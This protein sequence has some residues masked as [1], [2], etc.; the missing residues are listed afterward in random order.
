VGT[1]VPGG[2]YRYFSE[3]IQTVGTTH[4]A[5]AHLTDGTTTVYAVLKSNDLITWSVAHN[6]GAN[7]PIPSGA[8]VPPVSFLL[9]GKWY[10][11]AQVGANNSWLVTPDGTTFTTVNIQAA[12]TAFNAVLGGQFIPVSAA[13]DGATIRV[14]SPTPT[15]SGQQGFLKSTDNGVTWAYE[16]TGFSGIDVNSIAYGNG[17]WVCGPGAVGQ[18]FIWTS[19]TGNN[20]TW[21]QQLF[22]IVTSGGTVHYVTDV[23]FLAGLFLIPNPGTN[24]GRVSVFTSSDGLNYTFRNSSNYLTMT[25]PQNGF[26]SPRSRMCAYGNNTLVLAGCYDSGVTNYPMIS[27]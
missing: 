8:T 21:T 11:L 3:T 19:T 4:L 24:P 22:P 9:N 10:T 5:V 14:A 6:Y 25:A 15:V 1:V 17:I 16:S 26:A 20:G 27:P 23:T 13:T 18:Q 7:T 12:V 2:Y